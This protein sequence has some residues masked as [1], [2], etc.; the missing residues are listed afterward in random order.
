ME[1]IKIET[2]TFQ[3]IFDFENDVGKCKLIEEAQ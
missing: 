1:E 3:F 2:Y